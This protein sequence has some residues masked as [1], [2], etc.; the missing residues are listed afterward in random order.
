M[1]ISEYILLNEY[2]PKLFYMCKYSILKNVPNIIYKNLRR[3]DCECTLC[4][5]FL[6]KKDEFLFLFYTSFH[7]DSYV[8]YFRHTEGNEWSIQCTLKKFEYTRN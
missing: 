8:F 5:A 6:L 4:N 7:H 3:S 1:K 2:R